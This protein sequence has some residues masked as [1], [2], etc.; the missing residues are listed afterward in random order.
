MLWLIVKLLCMV[1]RIRAHEYQAELIK[2]HAEKYFVNAE[3]PYL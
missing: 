2:I 1:G 3:E